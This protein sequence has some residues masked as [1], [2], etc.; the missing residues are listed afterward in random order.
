M[1]CSNIAFQRLFKNPATAMIPEKAATSDDEASPSGSDD[2]E[3][4]VPIRSFGQIE[5]DAT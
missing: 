2:E 5:L 4:A 1:A 3:E